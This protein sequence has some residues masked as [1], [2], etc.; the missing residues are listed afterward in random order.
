M[1]AGPK[2]QAVS[3][4]Q[5]SAR[6]SYLLHIQGM[7]SGLVEKKETAKSGERHPP[8]KLLDALASESDGALCLQTPCLETE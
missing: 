1:Q 5:Y 8:G 2:V 4:Q 7:R 3:Q 6:Y